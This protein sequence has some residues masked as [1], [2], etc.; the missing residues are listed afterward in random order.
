MEQREARHIWNFRVIMVL[1]ASS[2]HLSEENICELH[3]TQDWLCA[4]LVY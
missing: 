3:T 2:E 1:T 4:I